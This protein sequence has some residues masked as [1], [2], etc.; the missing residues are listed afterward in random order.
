[1]TEGW[2]DGGRGPY[3][4]DDPGFWDELRQML[5]EIERLVNEGLR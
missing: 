1:M 2:K 3:N 4:H 5:D